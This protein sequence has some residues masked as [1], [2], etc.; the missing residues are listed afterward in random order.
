MAKLRGARRGVWGFE[1]VSLVIVDGLVAEFVKEARHPILW[2][3]ERKFWRLMACGWSS[4]EG[5]PLYAEAFYGLHWG[6]VFSKFVSGSL[7][8]SMF[9]VG[10]SSFSTAR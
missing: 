5:R 6:L 4:G 10:G 7:S 8:V 2:L 1:E 3:W 9:C